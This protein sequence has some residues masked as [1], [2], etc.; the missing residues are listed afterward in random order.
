MERG[1][2]GGILG[3]VRGTGESKS[4]L[5]S[6]WML[7]T[8]TDQMHYLMQGVN[9]RTV[10]REVQEPHYRIGNCP[11]IKR[12]LKGGKGQ[13]GLWRQNTHSQTPSD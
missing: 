13:S 1:A 10:G 6:I 2:R 4:Y 5:N 12:L 7:V 11:T 3:Q 8:I 9:S